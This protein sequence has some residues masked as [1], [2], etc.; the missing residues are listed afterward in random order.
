[1]KSERQRQQTE[2]KIETAV[3]QL[4]SNK[5]F[6]KMS[7]RDIVET[8]HISRGTFYLHYLDK[9]DLLEKYEDRLID[10]VERVFKTHAKRE[11]PKTVLQAEDNAF[12]WLF[13]YLDAHRQLVKALLKTPESQLAD[14][15]KQATKAEI[16]K[17]VSDAPQAAP[18]ADYNIPSAYACEMCSRQLLIGYEMSGQ[19]QLLTFSRFLSRATNYQP[20][21]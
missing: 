13:N 9:F 14:K 8:A 5:G 17:G 1:M 19:K 20:L 3:I 11:M 2:A 4:I 18:A 10:G 6:R 21:N 15:M 7:V 16:T 12:Y